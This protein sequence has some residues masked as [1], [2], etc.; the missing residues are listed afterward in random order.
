MNRDFQSINLV[1][2]SW[3]LPSTQNRRR[4][5]IARKRSMSSIINRVDD[6]KL[7]LFWICT[8]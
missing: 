2:P 8:Q 3:Q 7:W 1:H 6:I 4:R 5:C